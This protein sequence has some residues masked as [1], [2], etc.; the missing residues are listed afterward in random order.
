M[1]KGGKTT[2]VVVG[3][4]CSGTLVTTQLLSQHPSRRLQVVV[5][6]PGVVGRGVAYGTTS[7]SHLLNSPAG[8]MSAHCERPEHFVDWARERWADARTSSFLPRQVYGEYLRSVL[9]EAMATAPRS[10]SL[11]RH[12]GEVVAVNF[13]PGSRRALVGLADG[14]HIEADKVILALGNLPPAHPRGALAILRDPR[15]VSDPWARG[16]L[17]N[18]SGAVLLIGTGLTAIDVALALDDQG[19]S[20][21]V[22]AVS[23]HGL[24]PRAHLERPEGAHGYVREHDAP[25][26]LR[27]PME[28]TDLQSPVGS[29]DEAPDALTAREV[30]SW[31]R[32]KAQ[33]TGD[34]RAAVDGIRLYT[35]GI[36]SALSEEERMRFLRHLQRYWEVHRHRMAPEVASRIAEMVGCGRLRVHR[37]AVERLEAGGEGVRAIVRRSHPAATNAFDVAYVV[38]CT[39]PQS[40]VTTAG[41]RLLDNLLVSG[42]IRP[43]SMGLGIDVDPTGA[44]RDAHGTSNG[45]LWAIGPLCRGVLWETTAV[46][47]IR[48]QAAR[49]AALV[50]GRSDL[51]ADRMHSGLT[52]VEDSGTAGTPGRRGEVSR[53]VA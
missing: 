5:V 18:V 49:I 27:A 7:V 43:G 47:E 1:A 23:R 11:S 30:L 8:T 22:Y 33:Q 6:E 14:G 44:V 12:K 39:G 28:P 3:G 36:W 51:A 34:W 9:T 16:A 41:N 25:V 38:N 2:V 32:T 24:L 10:S 4:G 29:P 15:Y 46:P 19:R 13:R 35:A 20:G 40:D 45:V 53:I 52:R 50:T 42:H 31:L 26:G 17:T 48:A 37:G 21:P